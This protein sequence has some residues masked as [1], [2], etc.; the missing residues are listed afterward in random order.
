MS[1]SDAIGIAEL[2]AD[3]HRFSDVILWSFVFWVGADGAIALLAGALM[4]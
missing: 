2:R 1:N 4:R 3:Q